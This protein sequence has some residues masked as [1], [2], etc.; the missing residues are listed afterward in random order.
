MHDLFDLARQALGL[1]L[2]PKDLGMGQMA[3][4]SVVVFLAGL[5][6]VRLGPRRFLGQ[7]SAF[8]ALLWI[9]LG[10]VLSRG[11]N[12]SAPF[13]QTL[14][15][16]ALL[17]AIH[18]LVAWLAYESGIVG[19]IVKGRPIPLVL[20]GALR[21][22]AMRFTAVSEHDLL[23]TLRVKG[24]TP[25][26]DSVDEAYVERSGQISVLVKPKEPRIIEVSVEEGVK[27]IR[28]HL[29]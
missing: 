20:G 12:G 7:H 4:R 27:T 15:A 2:Q 19:R 8:D 1:D 10:S 14:G 16:S 23:E 13:F 26:L 22:A 24:K 11:I 29:E 17:V 18:W 6:M 5:A 3:L 9:I 28:I 21:R 25:R